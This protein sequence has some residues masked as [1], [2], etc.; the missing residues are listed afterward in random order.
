MDGGI[1]RNV[2]TKSN[3]KNG[4]KVEITNHMDRLWKI[5]GQ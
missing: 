3:W 1:V 4:Q 5:K 2:Q